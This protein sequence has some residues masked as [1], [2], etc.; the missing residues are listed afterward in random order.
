[1]IQ[2]GVKSFVC[3]V[4][5]H[6]IVNLYQNWLQFT[7]F[8]MNASKTYT[9]LTNNH[10]SLNYVINVF[11]ISIFNTLLKTYSFI[12]IQMTSD[13]ID[14]GIL[15]LRSPLYSCYVFQYLCTSQLGLSLW[16][17]CVTDLD[18]HRYVLLIAVTIQNFFSPFM[19]YHISTLPKPLSSH[20]VF[21]L[22]PVVH[23]FGCLCR[24]LSTIVCLFILL[25]SLYC[26]FFFGWRLLVVHLVSSNLLVP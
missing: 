5:I 11:L 7:H 23:L 14:N 4:C 8:K 19:T 26:L 20:P 16:S 21:K 2:L 13:G 10:L 25:W 18:D 22:I 24:V 12:C 15:F 3:D 6:M 17:I 1:M 9:W